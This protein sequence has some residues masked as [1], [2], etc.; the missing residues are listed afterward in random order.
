M[1]ATYPRTK[2]VLNLFAISVCCVIAGHLTGLT[3]VGQRP[4]QISIPPISLSGGKG[5]ASALS[6]NGPMFPAT[7][8]L[9]N[10]SATVFAKAAPMVA[11]YQLGPESSATITITVKLKSGDKTFTKFLKHTGAEVTQEVFQLPEEF[12][13]KPLVA[14][15]SVKAE[16]VDPT[17]KKP[18]NFSLYGLGMGKAV[19][20]LKIVVLSFEP[21]HVRATQKEK[22]AYSF[23]SLTDFD[24]ASVEFR[25]LRT[26]NGEPT[27]SLANSKNISGI[28]RDESKRG[29]WD[30]KDRKGKVSLGRHQLVVNG[31]YTQK[32]GGDWGHDSSLQ[33]VT[34]E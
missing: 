12:G 24:K 16:N 19:G 31:W 32:N 1:K 25:S 34:I 18:P 6:K 11:K 20:S 15:L 9:G 8:L 17:N 5:E 30:G 13:T 4:G 2:K 10:F 33:R 3:S 22:V 23:R 7:Y 21:P 28:R 29:E 26:S 27:N 14:K